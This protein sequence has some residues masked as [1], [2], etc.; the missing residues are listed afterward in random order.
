MAIVI[1]SSPPTDI[2]AHDCI[3][4]CFSSDTV[5]ASNELL[6]IAWQILDSADNP[7]SEPESVSPVSPGDV[8]CIDIQDD[9]KALV[10]TMI[11]QT[12]PLGAV[13]DTFIYYSIQVVAWEIVTDL[14][15]CT[16]VGSEPELIAETRIWNGVSQIEEYDV[17]L[18][19]DPKE[20][21]VL[22]H[23]PLVITQ[24]RNARNYI[25]V[26]STAGN[27]VEY[28][29]NDGA[30]SIVLS[31]PFEC[32]YV[33]LHIGDIYPLAAAT[34]PF[35]TLTIGTA[36][37]VTYKVYL[38]SCCCDVDYK[39]LMYLDPYGGRSTLSF[40]CV[41]EYRVSSQQSE[42]VRY[43]SCGAVSSNPFNDVYNRITAG[44]AT[45]TG[46]KTEERITLVATL[47]DDDESAAFAKAVLSSISYHIQYT[48]A[49]GIVSWRKFIVETG[50][51]VYRSSEGS[52]DIV[53]TGRMAMPYKTQSIDR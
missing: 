37:Y 33:P 29:D 15:T 5:P 27:K 10:T 22:S 12:D 48:D 53:F 24:C 44:G 14:A 23:L 16:T 39:N 21:T 43:I 26:K 52:V 51:A 7:L 25:W 45:I 40:Q 20:F 17:I 42:V 11:P 18:N 19:P 4:I 30:N 1:N 6:R 41:E 2:S 36:E 47:G 13:N 50:D 46:K 9:V 35:F 3:R 38:E 49:D 34:M 8:I 31:P 28:K 32:F